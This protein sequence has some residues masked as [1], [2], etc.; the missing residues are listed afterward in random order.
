VVVRSGT[1]WTQQALLEASNF[2]GNEFLGGSVVVSEDALRVGAPAEDRIAT[3]VNGNQNDH[4]A[5]N[6]GAAYLFSR[7]DGVW[8][9]AAYLKASNTRLARGSVVSAIPSSATSSRCL[10]VPW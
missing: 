7:S 6:A 3:G 2:G 5:R 10:A 9:Q 1:Q 4:T 8:T